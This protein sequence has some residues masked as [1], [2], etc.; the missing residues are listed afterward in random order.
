M[1]E[2]LFPALG[3]SLTINFQARSITGTPV[4][5]AFCLAETQ[6]K[7]NQTAATNA[8]NMNHALSVKGAITREMRILESSYNVG[9]KKGKKHQLRSTENQCTYLECVRDYGMK[10]ADSVRENDGIKE[11]TV[12]EMRSRGK[13]IMEL[14]QSLSHTRVEMIANAPRGVVKISGPTVIKV[15]SLPLFE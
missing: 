12:K 9:N 1:F 3:E 11:P 14:K 13:K 4:E 6:I 7:A 2:R 15:F 10:L 5:Q 8:K